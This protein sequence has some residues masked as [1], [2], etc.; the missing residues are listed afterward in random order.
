[1]NRKNS[2]GDLVLLGLE[3]TIDGYVRLEDFLSHTHIYARGYDRSLKKAS[4]AQ[5]LR[6]LRQKGFV[7]FINEK[8][9]LIK[10]TDEGRARALWEKVSRDSKAWD[11]KWRIVAFDIPQSHYLIRDLFRRRLK[12][13][14]FMQLQK[15]VWVSKI[16]C[17]DLL[18]MY[19][20]NL[21]IKKWVSVLEAGNVDFE[22]L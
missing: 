16:D 4:F 6:R 12:E 2:L 15:S 14:S 13:F 21:G 3:K 9:I 17:T 8:E 7:E 20:I 1:M 10:L 11:G 5:A 22:T 18:R 19:V